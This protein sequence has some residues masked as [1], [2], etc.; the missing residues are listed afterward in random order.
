MSITLIACL[1]LNNGIGD[2]NG[3]LLY[4][5]PRDLSNFQSITGGRIVVMGRKTWDSLPKKPLQKRKNYILTMNE[6]FNPIGA[7]VIHDI[8]EI[9]KL[10]KLHD[11]YCIGGGELYYQLIDDADRLIITHVHHAHPDAK[12]HFPD[13]GNKQWKLERFTKNEADEKHPHSFTFAEYTRKE[14]K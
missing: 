6:D 2:G 13:F 11:V 1:D 9:H 12:V 7:K 8:D 10:A 3:D 5:F 14:N 4:K